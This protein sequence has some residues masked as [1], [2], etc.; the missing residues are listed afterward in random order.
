M[1]NNGN[2]PAES[3]FIAN[4]LDGT[5]L[6]KTTKWGS[7]VYVYQGKNVV[8]YGG[9]K[10]YFSIWFYNGVFLED[11]RK[12][13]VSASEGKTKSLRQWRFNSITD[14][15]A[16]MILQYVKEAIE[17]EKKGLKIKPEKFAPI[18]IP[19][20]LSEALKSNKTLQ[21]SYN[22]LT[23]GR[24]KEYILFL[25]EAKQEATKQK[26]LEKIIPLIQNGLGLNDKYK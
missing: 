25:N 4:L 3:E 19:E 6:E 16:T 9:F 22:N 21:Q 5:E 8:S 26:R 15:D 13:L 20:L 2:W 24:Q 17:I 14:M 11:Q 23:P 10:H 7:D 18:P 1:Q 12:V